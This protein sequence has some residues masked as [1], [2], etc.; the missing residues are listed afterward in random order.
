MLGGAFWPG[1]RRKETP[2]QEEGASWP[3]QSTLEKV[4]SWPG[5]RRK[6]HSGQAVRGRRLLTRRKETPGQHKV[7]SWPG[8]RRKVNIGQVPGGR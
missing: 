2:G 3:E 6:V 4:A 8:A 7:A 5:T 1:G